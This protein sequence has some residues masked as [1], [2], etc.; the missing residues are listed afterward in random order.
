M[1]A[2]LPRSHAFHLCWALSAT[3][4]P[5]L[6]P[7]MIP[8]STQFHLFSQASLGI[9]AISCQPKCLWSSKTLFEPYTCLQLPFYLCVP[10]TATLLQ[11][12][13]IPGVEQGRP[14]LSTQTY[15]LIFSCQ[16]LHHSPASGHA[17]QIHPQPCSQTGLL[18]PSEPSKAGCHL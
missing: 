1:L 12:P 2:A 14:L 8:S 4:E 10:C 16:P 5:L 3:P 9:S 17:P 6:G 18:A 13:P 7:Q 15:R 11:R